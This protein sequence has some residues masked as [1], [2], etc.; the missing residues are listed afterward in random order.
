MSSYT[1]HVDAG[2]FR[3]FKSLIAAEYN[4][5]DIKVPKFELGKDNQ[6]PTFLAKSPQGK[7]P[8]LETANGGVITESNAIA[9]F[10]AKL[11]VDTE[12]TGATLLES[13]QVN[14]YLL[15]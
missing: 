5:V 14:F 1:L 10:V 3:A 4:G 7:V 2:N 11:R 15:A 8:V 9:R 13:A 6:T 12:L